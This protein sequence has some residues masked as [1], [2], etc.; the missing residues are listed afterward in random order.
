MLLAASALFS[1]VGCNRT[2]REEKITS[3]ASQNSPAKQTDVVFNM[4]K[5]FASASETASNVKNEF[6]KLNTEEVDELAEKQERAFALFMAIGK[7]CGD[8]AFLLEKVLSAS[9][10]T[11]AAKNKISGAA[12]VKELRKPK[13]PTG[14]APTDLKKLLF[15]VLE[16][17]PEQ[18]NNFK[19][20]NG[21]FD[22]QAFNELVLALDAAKVVSLLAKLELANFTAWIRWV[23]LA[24][25]KAAGQPAF[26]TLLGKA[27]SDKKEQMRNALLAAYA[28]DPIALRAMIDEADAWGIGTGLD[29]DIYVLASGSPGTNFRGSLLYVLTK[30]AI[31]KHSLPG[32]MANEAFEE[33]RGYAT[34]IKP[35]INNLVAYKQHATMTDWGHVPPEKIRTIL[36]GALTPSNFEDFANYFLALEC[37]EDVFMAIEKSVNRVS[38]AMVK[39]LF[40]KVIVNIVTATTLGLKTKAVGGLSFINL[41]VGRP[42]DAMGASIDML[43]KF[44]LLR[45]TE[46]T[47][48]NDNRGGAKP[49]QIL[50]RAGRPAADDATQKAKMFARLLTR[51]DGTAVKD[52]T[53]LEL[54]T[55]VRNFY[56]NT[57]PGGSGYANFKA[58]YQK[59]HLTNAQKR[60]MRSS[61]LAEVFAPTRRLDERR[62]FLDEVI[63]PANDI[64][65]LKPTIANILN[66]E[67]DLGPLSGPLVYLVASHAASL[68]DAPVP[69]MPPPGFI[70]FPGFVPPPSSPSLQE[71]ALHC[72]RDFVVAVQAQCPPGTYPNYVRNTVW[73][74]STILA[75]LQAKLDLTAI[76]RAQFAG[77][78]LAVPRKQEVYDAAL[79]PEADVP[80]DLLKD[81]YIKVI[82]DDDAKAVTLAGK[83]AVGSDRIIHRLLARRVDSDGCTFFVI[84]KILNSAFTSGGILAEQAILTEPGAGILPLKIILVAARALGADDAKQKLNIV[85]RLLKNANLPMMAAVN[86]ADLT[87]IMP[88]LKNNPPMFKQTYQLFPPASPRA[89]AMR[90]KLL[91]ESYKTMDGMNKFLRDIGD[92]INDPWG[93]HAGFVINAVKDT[94]EL[95]RI[96]PANP[97]YSGTLLYVLVMRALEE[98]LAGEIRAFKRLT[99]YATI[100]KALLSP[101]YNAYVAAIEHGKAI[102]LHLHDGLMAQPVLAF[103]I[104]YE[105]AYLALND[106]RDVFAAALN[107]GVPNAV[108]K[109]R[110]ELIIGNDHAKAVLLGQ[111]HAV[112]Q[113]SFIEAL[114][115]RVVD[116]HTGIILEN[117]LDSIN[118]AALPGQGPADERI[119]LNMNNGGAGIPIE[120]LASPRP[121]GDNLVSKNNMARRLLMHDDG[122]ALDNVPVA[123]VANLDFFSGGRL[124]PEAFKMMYQKFAVLD[125]P[126]AN[127]QRD[128]RTLAMRSALLERAYQNIPDLQK[129]IE[130]IAILPAKV[131]PRP[132]EENIWGLNADLISNTYTLGGV[133]GSLLHVITMQTI[134]DEH[135][136][137]PVPH[138]RYRAL[139]EI[140]KL[141]K[142][143]LNEKAE[144]QKVAQVNA[145][146]LTQVQIELN[147]LNAQYETYAST[148]PS[149]AKAALNAALDVSHPGFAYFY[150]HLQQPKILVAPG[151]Y[152]Q[153]EVVMKAAANTNATF[154]LNVL[155]WLYN[156]AIVDGIQAD[157]L[158]AR[159][160]ANTTFMHYMA[161]KPGKDETLY[162]VLFDFLAKIFNKA[163]TDPIASAHANSAAAAITL[164][165]TSA[166]LPGANPGAIGRATAGALGAPPATIAA[167][168]AGA[169]A[170]AAALVPGTPI[171]AIATAAANAAFAALPHANNLALGFAA[172]NA[173]LLPNAT[174]TTVATEVAKAAALNY[175]D[176]AATAFAAN[177]AA[178]AA[179]AV[180]GADP[181]TIAA[182]AAAAV[183]GA[184]P[185]TIRFAADA[186]ATAADMLAMTVPGATPAA[187]ALDIAAAAA[188]AAATAASVLVG[189]P[190]TVAIAAANAAIAPG[191]T[192]VTI[193]QATSHAAIIA[194]AAATESTIA[195]T[196]AATIAAT[197]TAAPAAAA[198]LI[199]RS[200]AKAKAEILGITKAAQMSAI[201]PGGLNTLQ[202]V[203]DKNHP[204]F[205]VTQI[206]LIQLAVESADKSTIKHSIS[207]DIRVKTMLRGID[208]SMPLI[209]RVFPNLED[210]RMGEMAKWVSDKTD[211]YDIGKLFNAEYKAR[212]TVQHAM[213]NK[214]VK[215]AVKI[216]E[217]ASPNLPFSNVIQ[218]S[219]N[220]FIDDA[221]LLGKN[222]NAKTHGAPP[223]NIL[224]F[225]IENL[226]STFDPQRIRLFSDFLALKHTPHTWHSYKDDNSRL[227]TPNG[228]SVYELIVRKGSVPTLGLAISKAIKDGLL[229]NT[230]VQRLDFMPTIPANGIVGA[231]NLLFLVLENETIDM[232]SRNKFITHIPIFEAKFA[233]K[234]QWRA[235]LDHNQSGAGNPNG[236]S[237]LELLSEKLGNNLVKA[238][239]WLNY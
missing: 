202:L 84:N 104:P 172:N 112:G 5:K 195:E 154:D 98:R 216:G 156:E 134:A 114:V 178:T 151:I 82:G 92:A 34:R 118:R 14:E 171:G 237:A 45:G 232:N 6:E 131:A 53:N 8:S 11:N 10:S 39:D 17:Y 185:A 155:Q 75:M 116:C 228:E 165:A 57:G 108:L 182:A 136:G 221:T 54:T 180:P 198:A 67:Y 103:D 100:I 26:K 227:T 58:I 115:G 166:V 201:N 157:F 205:V 1:T 142:D 121:A 31:R 71:Q 169:A 12:L 83:G 208:A 120:L 236:K 65:G 161:V 97:P 122:T 88:V 7:A 135:G 79:R 15:L 146:T 231:S 141:I 47:D 194:A 220:E 18:I 203:L 207:N 66:D 125:A 210:A 147:F 60:L 215:K 152:D 94:Y 29:T 212:P 27:P 95:G 200:A 50:G 107:A 80:N 22:F 43:D 218:L 113:R 229:D 30:K 206:P 130:N 140:A 102:T 9:G 117:F 150:L 56:A 3:L 111:A 148:A 40:D 199:A 124:G 149:N 68:S 33:L 86:V 183:P 160:I 106:Y 190:A 153:S 61:L 91:S 234:A 192:A 101:N 167:A 4:A 69:Y 184:T 211:S 63:D 51:D 187:I 239:L 24:A 181:A 72:L 230:T 170:A 176:P 128:A 168:A 85:S 191:A 196:I 76:K 52:L 186:A 132:A 238:S 213:L 179:G 219:D 62:R 143:D 49:I 13:R 129:L 110:Y 137:L 235:Y 37:P 164:A 145:A 23:T 163:Q 25:N 96:N 159:R 226:S 193:A 55:M 16:K 38:N 32:A 223:C 162:K 188:T 73:G 175:D 138:A 189:T 204:A 209:S 173:A 133:T 158:G 70:P 222:F 225:A 123:N 90:S 214:L 44:L 21:S 28:D 93:L 2:S 35:V 81:L 36:V 78:F 99:E 59:A 48:L 127:P 42:A 89:L 144:V 217:L 174:I 64:W 119:Q 77:Y 46:L 20:A 177:T 19:N 197:K 139:R 87:A 105:G 224:Y 109:K 233:T 126:K 41:L 74:G